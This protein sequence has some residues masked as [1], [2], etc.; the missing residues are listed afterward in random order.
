MHA[1]PR[2]QGDNE[3]VT[4]TIGMVERRLAGM[5][6]AAGRGAR[7]LSRPAD[8]RHPVVTSRLLA[9][10][11]ACAAV[12]LAVSPFDA[13]LLR[14]ARANQDGA[15]AF[16]QALTDIGLSQWYLVPAAATLLL[17][18]AIDWRAHGPSGKGRL[19]ILFGHAV[20]IFAGI[21]LSGMLTN[22]LKVLF[23]RS[24]PLRF[25]D[26]GAYRLDLWSFGYAHASFPSGHAT[27]M[28]A[29]TAIL[30]LWFPAFAFPIVVSGCFV[31]VTRIFAQA[32]YASDVAAGFSLGFVFVVL[33]ARFLAARRVVFMPVAGRILP[34]PANLRRLWAGSAG[35]G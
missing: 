22:L 31:A 10:M 15:A 23:G 13:V 3:S 20:F 5:V 4:G 27:T 16:M 29:V 25:D 18:A 26:V 32:H 6:R 1:P 30:C 33:M 8:P 24:R 19:S 12:T 2:Q 14:N 34:R 17:V 35:S 9:L 11:L 7:R 21:L 28:G